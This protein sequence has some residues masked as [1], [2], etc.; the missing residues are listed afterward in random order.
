MPREFL[1]NDRGGRRRE[2]AG[3]VTV[4]LHGACMGA[5][6]ELPAGA[7]RV[8]ARRDAVIALPEIALGLV[9]GAGGT[10]TIPQRIGRQRTAWLALTGSSI[11]ALTAQEWGL[12]DE[13]DDDSPTTLHNP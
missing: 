2:V 4:R 11:D 1:D 3:R 12:V 6:I 7:G 10:W 8:I 5:G 9:P 13:I